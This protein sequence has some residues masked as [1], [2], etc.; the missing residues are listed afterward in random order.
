[1]FEGLD[2]TPLARS[3]LVTVIWQL[4]F[5]EH[6]TLIAPQTALRLQELLGGSAAF[7]LAMLP[8]IQ[9]SVQS[10][11]SPAAE[12]LPQSAVGATG[13]GWRLSAAD[14]SWHV[15]V[16]AGSVSLESSRYGTWASDF[17]ARLQRVLEAIVDIG[18]PIVE[19]RLGLR[20]INVLVGSAVGRPPLSAP[21]ELTGLIASW[22]LG[23]LNEQQLQDSVQMTQG[24]A[25]FRF[26]NASAILNH[27][28]VSTETG[29]LGY[30]VD[31]DA[32]REGGRAFQS[33]DVLAQSAILHSIALGL[34]QMSLTP[35]ILKSMRSAPADGNG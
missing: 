21:S 35:E 22:L 34:F 11:G 29:E 10:A 32:F 12:G 3:P 31:I 6:P 4:R 7:S 15:N 26:E 9:L 8:R 30:L 27:G 13:G 16:E 23:P 19:S 5:E 28:V 17:S 1:M 2:E 25:A 20:Y 18:P 14:E 24:R 33:S